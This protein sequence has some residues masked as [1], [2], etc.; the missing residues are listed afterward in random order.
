MEIKNLQY[1][2]ISNLILIILNNKEDSCLRKN[3]EIELKLRLRNVGWEYNDLLHF[4]DRVISQRGLDVNNYLLSKGVDMQKLMEIYFM[5][6]I[7]ADYESNGLLFSEKH[8]CNETDLRSQF[9]N[10]ICIREIQNLNARLLTSDSLEEKDILLLVKKAL[11]ERQERVIKERETIKKECFEELLCFNE[12]MYQL[13]GS[14][15]TCHEF[16]YNY[17]DEEIYKLLKSKLGVFKLTFMEFLN[18]GLFGFDLIQNICGMRFIRRDS[19]KLSFQKRQ[20]L[21]QVNSGFEVN[22]STENIQKALRK[23]I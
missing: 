8:L 15:S 1:L 11:E 17:S 10:K 16:G 3:A 4:D 9:F 6:D 19:S 14:P 5:Y 20:L 13:D 21:H 23:A 7:N 12:A 22:Y 2:S 18:D